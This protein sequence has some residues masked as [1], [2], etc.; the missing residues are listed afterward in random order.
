MSTRYRLYH[1]AVR[2]SLAALLLLATG[3]LAQ[4]PESGGIGEDQRNHAQAD[5]TAAEFRP[6]ITEDE[7]AAA[8][9]AEARQRSEQNAKDDL[10]AQQS[11][12]RSTEEL[13]ALTDRQITIGIV[14]AAFLVLTVGFTGWAAWSAAA[15]AR[16]TNSQVAVARET[17]ERQLRAYLGIKEATMS[18]GGA[19]NV[20]GVHLEFVN[21]GQTP[22]HK[23]QMKVGASLQDRETYS[24]DWEKV[25]ASDKEESVVFPGI[26]QHIAPQVRLGR[27]DLAE[28]RAGRKM[29]VVYA[30]IIYRDAFDR[31]RRYRFSCMNV[32]APD[33]VLTWPVKGT[34]YP[35]EST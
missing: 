23:C 18:L 31:E 35:D 8:V 30:L 17:A 4:E 26:S 2:G 14:E 34:K 6:T 5:S 7:R 20:I 21:C 28:F 16:A 25:S 24:I 10:A 12:A 13:V 32:H 29:V 33:G 11:M 9:D 19:S 22:A 3:A 1:L 27:G 15:A